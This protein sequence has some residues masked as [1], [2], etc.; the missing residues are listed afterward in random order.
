MTSPQKRKGDAAELGVSRYLIS[1][2]VWNERIP[3]GATEDRGD[4]LIVGW[5]CEIKSYANQTE[6]IRRAL[7]D[8]EVAKA[9]TRKPG[10]AV[11][12]RNGKADPGEWLVTMTLADFCDTVLAPTNTEVS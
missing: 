6:G 11:I 2:G 9:T 12:K 8:L 5:C 4:L 10:F 3:A 1:Q 7:E